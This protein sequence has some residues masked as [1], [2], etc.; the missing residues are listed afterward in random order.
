[1]KKQNRE[2]ILIRNKR[3]LKKDKKELSLLSKQQG[4]LNKKADKGK[5][6]KR[7]FPFL[8]KNAKRWDMSN[9]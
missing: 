9:R 7:I 1:M 8:I 6:E 4:K 3:K 2:Q 5:S